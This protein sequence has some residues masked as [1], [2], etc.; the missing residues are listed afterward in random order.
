[1]RGRRPAG[2]CAPMRRADRGTRNHPG[3]CYRA[4]TFEIESAGENRTNLQS[5]LSARRADRRTSGPRAAAF[6]VVRG[7]GVT[8]LA[9]GTGGRVDPALRPRSSTPSGMPPARQPVGCRRGVCKFLDTSCRPKS[10]VRNCERARRRG[11]T[12]VPTSNERTRHTCSSVTPSPSRLVAKPHRRGLSDTLRPD[13]P[14]RRAHARN[15]RRPGADVC[16]RARGYRL[17]DGLARLGVMPRTRRPRR[18]PRT[19]RHRRQ[20]EKQ[21]SIGEFARCSA[22]DLHCRPGFSDS[23]DAG[24]G[25]KSV[26]ASA[27]LSSATSGPRPMKLVVAGR[28]FPGWYR[29]YAAAENPRVARL[30]ELE[31]VQPEWVTPKPPRPQLD[32]VESADQN[33]GRVGDQDLAAVAGR[34]HARRPIQHRTEVVAV[35]KGRFS[36]RHTP[37]GPA[38]PSSA[39]PQSPHRRQISATRTPQPHHR[40]CA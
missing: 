20:F 40:R 33:R 37:F 11:R 6:G 25:D 7:R 21:D 39:A 22:G 38:I 16:P 19:D 23:A 32:Q 9:A 28:R 26:A 34:H 35:L 10:P 36:G 17:R 3:T 5:F 8:P 27:S 13:R 2:I 1:M 15:C 4:S 18:E 30:L 24:Q 31:T 29:G 12:A 14:R